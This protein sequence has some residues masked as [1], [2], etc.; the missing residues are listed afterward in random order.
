MMA[1]AF[2]E[3]LFHAGLCRM[4]VVFKMR[5]G[6][7]VWRWSARCCSLLP[8]VGCFTGD[9]LLVAAHYA[10]R[11]IIIMRQMKYFHYFL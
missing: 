11:L 2:S 1:G 9:D 10:G 7:I 5:K 3:V 6:V 4:K 8:S